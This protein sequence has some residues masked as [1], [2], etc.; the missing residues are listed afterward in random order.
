M[1]AT[2]GNASPAASPQMRLVLLTMALTVGASIVGALYWRGW[3]LPTLVNLVVN[4]LF[5]SAIVR[6]RDLEIG[7][8]FLIGLVAAVVELLTSDPTFVRR[9]VLVYEPGGPFLVD[10]PLYMPLSWIFLIVQIGVISR[11]VIGRWGL[12]TAALVM[13]VTG[14]VNG[15]M[16][17]FLAQYSRLWYYRNCWMAGGLPIFVIVSEFLIGFVLPLAVF[18]LQTMTAS[19]AI[20]TVSPS[21]RGPGSRAW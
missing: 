2:T 16:Y 14:A 13:G 1:I 21:A 7:R 4:G 6:R 18:R 8:L 9:N 20:F 11:W 10:S 5:I 12:R 17:E 3:V 19:K 15:P